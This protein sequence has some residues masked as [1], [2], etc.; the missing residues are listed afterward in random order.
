MIEEIVLAIHSKELSPP[1]I[2]DIA[3]HFAVN[4]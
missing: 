3:H 1:E 4:N 2:A